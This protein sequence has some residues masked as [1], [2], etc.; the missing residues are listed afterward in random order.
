MPHRPR[1]AYRFWILYSLFM[2]KTDPS[3]P[4]SCSVTAAPLSLNIRAYCLRSRRPIT[5]NLF[6]PPVDTVR[7]QSAGD[8]SYTDRENVIAP[9]E[10]RKKCVA[11]QCDFGQ[12]ESNFRENKYNLV[13]GEERAPSP[14]LVQESLLANPKVSYEVSLVT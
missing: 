1:K 3:P 9:A 7:G 14:K 5:D 11:M 8:E 2:P 6:S 13:A 10:D 12:T 4:L